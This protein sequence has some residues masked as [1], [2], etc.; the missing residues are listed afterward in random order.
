MPKIMDERF[1]SFADGTTDVGILVAIVFA[2]AAFSQ[3]LVGHLIDK[4][5]VKPVFLAVLVIQVPILFALMRLIELPMFLGALLLMCTVFG[6]IPIMDTL[7]ARH[8]R[9][10]W[11]SR[12]YAVKYV[13]ALGVAA[14]A[15]PLVAFLHDYSGGFHLVFLV[16]AIAAAIITTAALLL[17]G[18]LRPAV[19]P[20]TGD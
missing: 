2:V 5:P 14:S 19:Q 15:V 8:T 3:I 18:G 11:R 9:D 10:E 16:L 12:V 4:Y 1:T 17:P 6:Q 7:V 13:L 20:A